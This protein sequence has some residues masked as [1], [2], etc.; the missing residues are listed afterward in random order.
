MSEGGAAV[1]PF[2]VEVPE[3]ELEDLRERLGRTRWPRPGVVPDWGQ[4]APLEY[5]R[6]LCEYWR[7]EYDWR[8]LEA[9]LNAL[10]QFRAEV[11]GVGIHFIHVR[12]PEPGAT[13]LVM[14]H[15]WP[16]SVL[17]F[18]KRVSWYAKKMNPCRML[19]DEVRAME[20]AQQF[21]DVVRRF[22]D[23]RAQRDED[24]RAG[25]I[26]PRCEEEEELVEA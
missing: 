25:R 26:A 22:L 8:R 9:R 10:P 11:D 14:T 16:G 24:V 21:D 4:G 17:E 5:V 3:A 15:G 6:E 1:E 7:T 12:S 20:T 19:K 13:P 2:R 23:W 18:R